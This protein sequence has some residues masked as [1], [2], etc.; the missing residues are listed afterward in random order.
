MK[1]I[2]LNLIKDWP[3]WQVLHDYESYLCFLQQR[4]WTTALPISDKSLFSKVLSLTWDD[5]FFSKNLRIYESTNHQ[6]FFQI[7]IHFPGHFVTTKARWASPVRCAGCWWWRP[8]R[9]ST[10]WASSTAPSPSPPPPAT[11]FNPSVCPLWSRLTWF[12]K[13]QSASFNPDEMFEV[14]PNADKPSSRKMRSCQLVAVQLVCH[15]GLPSLSLWA[16]G[17]RRP[18][19]WDSLTA[20]A[21]Q[22]LRS[23]WGRSG[24]PV[25][26]R[27][28]GRNLV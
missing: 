4:S 11:S 20:A 21:L 3:T 26:I 23:A 9:A 24:N 14:P 17:R 28:W 2:S 18:A 1:P 19:Y 8:C 13:H 27:N 6:S 22:I 7:S 5:I 10:S 16:T 12:T 25:E 15:T